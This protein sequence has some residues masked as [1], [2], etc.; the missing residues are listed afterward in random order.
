MRLSLLD[1]SRTRTDYPE[2]AALQHSVER[3]IGAEALGF[4][5]FWGAEHHA[6]PGVASG[7]P[8]VLLA[9]VG[10]RT[11]QIRLGS[12]GVMLP[13]HQPIVVAEQF[14]MLEALYPGR[15]DL[16]VGRSLGFT[17]PVRRALRQQDDDAE[18]FAADIEEL[19]SFLG[20]E[21]PVT[22]RPVAESP[23][24]VFLLATGQGIATAARL[25][26]PVV[27]GGPVLHSPDVPGMLA[28]YRR[29]FHSSPAAPEPSV[30][31]S[32][33]AFVA[34][35]ESDARELALPEAWSMARSRETGRFDALEPASAIRSRTWSP[36]AHQRV[37]ENL[38][39]VI[40]GPREAVRAEVEKLLETT[41][42]EELI[43]STSTYDRQVQDE[44]DA[45][46]A[47]LILGR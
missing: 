39:R 27:I 41:G 13:H 11:S 46:L 6:V 1:R 22:A 8:A 44:L 19:R 32:L 16:G 33:D 15:I 38:Q 9:A 10:A 23:P 3:A 29:G 14:L 12:G 45:D 4:H 2:S 43:L 40:A 26:L 20:G 17:E 25:G 24:E 37:E 47:H 35:T 5:R 7:A 21:A 28:E 30:I 42:A 36:R 34:D 31:I 18:Q